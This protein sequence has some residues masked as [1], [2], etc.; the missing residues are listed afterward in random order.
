[1]V[2][3]TEVKIAHKGKIVACSEDLSEQHPDAIIIVVE[4]FASV[5]EASDH[6]NTV[7]DETGEVQADGAEEVLSLVNAQHRANC[8]NQARAKHARPKSAFTQLKEKAKDPANKAKIEAL[9]AELDID[10]LDL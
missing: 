3:A 5:E 4:E 6:F 10:G 7:D 1:M 8:M 2:N 9:L